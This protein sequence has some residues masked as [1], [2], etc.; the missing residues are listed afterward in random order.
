MISAGYVEHRLNYRFERNNEMSRW[1]LEFLCAGQVLVRS[2]QGQQHYHESSVMLVPPRT[3][4]SVEWNGEKN[5]EE[6]KELYVV[7]DPPSHWSPLL[8]W[9]VSSCGTGIIHLP[10]SAI[11]AEVETVL[12]TLCQIQKIPRANQKALLFNALEQALL[13]LDE[14]NPLRGYR[15]QDE[16]IS[17]ALENIAAR[18]DTALSLGELAREV[19][20]SPSRFSHLFQEQMRIAPMQYLEQYRLDRAAEKLLSGEDSIEQ[21][22]SAVGFSNPFHF[23]TRFRLRFGKPPSRYRNDPKQLES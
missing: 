11:R 1:T 3:P 9:P 8:S 23:S 12:K 15:Q 17:Q 2:L 18:Y 4:Y 21:I 5:K 22:A 13:I 14:L 20:L 6:W 16:R 19:Y 7:F 10:T